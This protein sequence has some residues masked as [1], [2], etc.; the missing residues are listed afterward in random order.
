MANYNDT[1]NDSYILRL[2]VTEGEAD[3]PNNT[4]PV[5]YSLAILKGTGSGKF[6]TAVDSAWALN[7]NGNIRNG[8]TAYD[9]RPLAQGQALVLASGTFT[10]PHNPDGTKTIS[11]SGSFTD[12]A[13]NLV[14]SGSVAGSLVLARIPRFGKRWDGTNEIV[15]TTAMRWDGTNEIPL[16]EAYRWDGTQEVRV[17]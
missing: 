11:V 15:I 4:S 7:I 12:G 2:T 14:G 17:S 1:L 10:I 16:T 8:A 13:G 5:T 3:V 6:R 9:F